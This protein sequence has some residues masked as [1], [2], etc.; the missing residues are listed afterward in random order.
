MSG[1]DVDRENSWLSQWFFEYEINIWLLAIQ[2]LRIFCVFRYMCVYVRC[3]QCKTPFTRTC[4][5]MWLWSVVALAN[6]RMSFEAT[7]III[8]EF[9]VVVNVSNIHKIQHGK[10]QNETSD[11]L[12]CFY[13]YSVPHFLSLQ[14]HR[15][16]VFSLLLF[17]LLYFG[18]L[19]VCVF[20]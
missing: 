9:N 12:V 16:A 18:L 11:F 3:T 2:R 6:N 7:V 15:S 5:T 10:N 4:A 17:L 1:V 13:I 14:R 8:Y 19:C 20:K